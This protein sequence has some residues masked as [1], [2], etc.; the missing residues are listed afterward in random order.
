MKN[1]SHSI[2]IF[3]VGLLL[4]V[5]VMALEISE[6]SKFSVTA[7]YSTDYI[8]HGYSKS[9]GKGVFQA[10]LDY[11]HSSGVFGGI[12]FSQADFGDNRVFMGNKRVFPNVARVEFIPYLGI[13]FNLSEDW[14][15]D[16]HWRRY[17][18]D[19]DFFGA[20]G[21]YNEFSVSLGFRDL[22]TAVIGITDDGYGKGGVYADYELIGRYPVTD[23]ID[24]SAKTGYVQSRE[25][26]KFDYFFWDAGLTFY[27]QFLGLDFRYF[28]SSRMNTKNE[29]PGGFPAV[30][31]SFVFTISLAY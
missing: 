16:V 11:Q 26:L 23:L 9:N 28:Q 24:F 10:N 22:V 12:W 17:I 7:I 6:D 15:G 20:S 21:D 19:D 3:I 31:P 29:M 5:Q 2:L 13:K 1:M 27:Y 30:E 25:A 14:H 18:Y 4:S 8:W